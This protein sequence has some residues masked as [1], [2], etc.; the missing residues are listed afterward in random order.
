MPGRSLQPPRP[1]PLTG[2]LA[3]LASH[4]D[5]LPASSSIPLVIYVHDC[6]GLGREVDLWGERLVA[7]GYAVIAPDSFARGGRAPACP[8]RDLDTVLT[9]ESE[10]RYA[11]QQAR[12]TPWVRQRA[13]FVLG[14]GQGA[15]IVA[16]GGVGRVTGAVIIGGSGDPRRVS[17]A[18]VRER[19]GP[20]GEEDLAAVVDFLQ[21]L[22]PR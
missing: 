9:R 7:Q 20:P 5:Q 4:I 16:R 22:T 12:A 19:E 14:V 18:L 3:A 10:L 1:A 15:T 13:V 6:T 17:P 2:R 8:P 11:V 21:R